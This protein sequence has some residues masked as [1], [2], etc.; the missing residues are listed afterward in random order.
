MEVV[1]LVI[2]ILLDHQVI[3][4]MILEIVHVV[5]VMEENYAN[6]VSLKVV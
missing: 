1:I 3:L 4:V 6:I 2:V 5:L